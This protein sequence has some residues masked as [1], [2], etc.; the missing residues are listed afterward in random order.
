M[1]KIVGWSSPVARQPHK[2]EVAGSNPAPA[3]KLTDIANRPIK[4]RSRVAPSEPRMTEAPGDPKPAGGFH[5]RPITLDDHGFLQAQSGD[6]ADKRFS[7]QLDWL[8]FFIRKPH[9]HQ[10]I[11]VEDGV[12]VAWGAIVNHYDG[13]ELKWVV[14]KPFRNKGIG[15]RTASA[16]LSR[17][18]S[19][20]VYAKIKPD[21][22][23]SQKIANYCG[24]K[25]IPD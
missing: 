15:K 23:A 14:S 21:N 17:T 4:G 7:N 16:L 25:I 6:P 2:L 5:L 19:I 9:W 11:A 13:D 18:D 22:I 20:N 10:Y 12:A 1:I 24:I 3:T 8:R